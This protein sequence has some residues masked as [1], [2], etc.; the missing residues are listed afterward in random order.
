MADRRGHI[1]KAEARE[2]AL[3]ALD[4]TGEPGQMAILDAETVEYEFGWV[5]RARAAKAIE[6][7]DPK[8][9]VPG[10]GGIAVDR[11]TGK[12]SFLPTFMPP[13]RAILAHNEEWL[14]KRKR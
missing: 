13:A 3:K 10:V 8:Y 11:D 4:E 9:D 2:S 6:T 5:F 14:A 12:A 1:S 7:G